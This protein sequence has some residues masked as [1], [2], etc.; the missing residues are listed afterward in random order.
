MTPPP[1]TPVEKAF[2]IPFAPGEAASPDQYTPGDFILTHGRGFLSWLI[3]FGQRLR[4]FG[5][6]RKYAWW[7]HAALITSAD[8]EIIEADGDCVIRAHLSDYTPTEYY[9]V[10]LSPELADQRDRNQMVAFAVSS[11]REKYDHLAAISIALSLLTGS[12]LAFYFEGQSMCSG[13]VARALERTNAI[14]KRSPAHTLPADL[15]MSFEVQAPPR[16]TAKGTPP[17]WPRPSV[18]AAKAA[19]AAAAIR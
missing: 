1:F 8:G 17:P 14:F 15:A 6:N 7:S 13:L 18:V 4:F 2:F 11:L 9:I 3:R 19:A 12:R 16:G 5:E 10:R